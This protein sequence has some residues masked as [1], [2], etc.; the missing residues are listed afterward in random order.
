MN[1]FQNKRALAWYKARG[2]RPR[3][4]FNYYEVMTA[5]TKIRIATNRASDS[6]RE[7]GKALAHLSVYGYVR[8]TENGRVLGPWENLTPSSEPEAKPSSS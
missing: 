6:A 8:V 7:L 4:P 5:L 1:R 3:Y 2:I